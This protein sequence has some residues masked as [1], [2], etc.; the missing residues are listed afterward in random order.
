[1]AVVNSGSNTLQVFMFDGSDT[2]TQIGSGPTQFKPQ[3]LSWSP[4][5][6]FIAVVNG[7]SNTL[8]MFSFDGVQPPSPIGSI[9]TDIYPYSVSWSPDGKFIAVINSDPFS[10][11]GGLQVF[12]VNYVPDKSIQAISNGVVFGDSALG[13]DYDAF[14]KVLAG[15][16]VN[17]D[18][19]V[20]Y[21]CVN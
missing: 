16:K 1:M 13:T 5:G 18:G 15:A 9:G 7:D 19:K 20:N 4:N 10:L 8:E 11:F 12:K 21:D 3:S 14:V 6:K 17:V 2:P